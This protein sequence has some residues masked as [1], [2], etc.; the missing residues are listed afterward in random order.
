MKLKSI[1]PL[2]SCAAAL[3]CILVSGGILAEDAVGKTASLGEDM[4]LIPAGPFVMGS[5]KLPNKDES[6]GV[7]TIKPWYL[8]EHPTHK[9][10]LPAYYIDRYEITNAEYQKFVVATGH[11][12]PIMWGENGYLL[13]LRIKA[14]TQLDIDRL[15][16]LAVKTF[17]LDMD[18]RTMG[19]QAL[20][21]AVDKRLH[22]LDKEP[23]IDVSWHDA[24]AYCNWAGERLPSEAEW[25]KAARGDKGS[26]FPWGDKWAPGKSNTGEET[27]DDGVAPVG[28]YPTDKS[29]YGV[30]DMAGNVS[31]WVEDWYQPYPGA[32]YQ[33]DAFGKKF[34]VLRGAAWGREG[35]YAMHQFQRGAYRFY[36]DPD[37]ILEDVGFRCANSGS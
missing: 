12:P 34:K 7:G 32:T 28:S 19:K 15:R 23:V 36:L 3:A 30:F 10:S 16:R 9:V 4:V 21:D 2:Q 29:P 26:E 14:L 35:H 17:R 20:L 13:N 8:D 22:Y 25:E 1:K 37:S 27:W 24:D 6:T 31:E 11:T 5:D 18:T 33:S